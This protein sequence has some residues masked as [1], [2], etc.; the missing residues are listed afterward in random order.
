MLAR[1]YNCELMKRLANVRAEGVYV[2][3]V[4]AQS[5]RWR[6]CITA[7]LLTQYATAQNP[8]PPPAPANSTNLTEAGLAGMWCEV[9]SENAWT[10]EAGS[11]LTVVV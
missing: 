10:V 9:G 2:V 3:A 11:G 7:C 5:L 8:P 6:L 1:R 4:Q